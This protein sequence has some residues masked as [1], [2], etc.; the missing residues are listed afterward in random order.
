[1][2]RIPVTSSNIASVGYDSA[3]MIL[4]IEFYGGGIYQYYNVPESTF[5]DMLN[6][7]CKG[8]YFD[9]KIKRAKYQY[10][11]LSSQDFM[12]FEFQSYIVK[13]ME[14]NHDFENI[15]PEYCLKTNMSNIDVACS[16][17][18][19]RTLVEIKSVPPFTK[20]RLLAYIAQLQQYS[21]VEPDAVLVLLFP[22]SM[23]Q[24][25]YDIATKSH[26]NVWDSQKISEIFSDQLVLLEHTPVYHLFYL[27]PM[28]ICLFPN[29]QDL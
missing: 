26:I 23:S 14:K 9:E 21:K 10:Q 8:Q 25:Y 22:G 7:S 27:A 17:K 11:R 24:E 12:G 28:G 2:K 20:N 6:S 19:K 4:E 18:G 13:M 15:Q 3:K 5:R 1:M 29:L 16:Y